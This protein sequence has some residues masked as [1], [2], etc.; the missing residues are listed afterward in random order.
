MKTKIEVTYDCFDG[1]INEKLD[2]KIKEYLKQLNAEWYAQGWDVENKK[3]D[4]CFDW[5]IE[6][7]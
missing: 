3:R 6:N 7:S 1:V 5:E 4:I 2:E